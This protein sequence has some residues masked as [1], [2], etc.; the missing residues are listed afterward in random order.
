VPQAPPAEQKVSPATAPAKKA[1]S[2]GAQSKHH[3]DY[4]DI[5]ITNI[6]KVIAKR[7]LFSKVKLKLLKYLV[8][9]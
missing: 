6:R 2:T 4:E 8:F 3:V 7:L 5:E 9:F 1:P